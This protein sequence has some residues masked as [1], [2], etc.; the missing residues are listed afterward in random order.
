M[1]AAS[2]SCSDGDTTNATAGAQQ[3]SAAAAGLRVNRPLQRQPHAVSRSIAVQPQS[4]IKI[5][6]AVIEEPQSK[7][8][9]EPLLPMSGL[10]VSNPVPIPIAP[11]SP[12]YLRNK[13]FKLW[14]N[15]RTALS[16]LFQ[17]NVSYLR[18]QRKHKKS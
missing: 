16:T 11:N 13:R 12:L 3:R 7:Q 9:L 6:G 17:T 10:A 14:G 8:I 1:V 18:K 2:L 4:P 5:N 15:T